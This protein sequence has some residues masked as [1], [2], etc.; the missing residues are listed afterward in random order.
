M[1]WISVEDKPA[2]KDRKFLAT[3]GEDIAVLEYSEKSLYILSSQC[4]C[5]SGYCSFYFT[6]WT[7]LPDLPKD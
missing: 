1:D 5:C 7:E 6:H 4:S 3:D 2:P